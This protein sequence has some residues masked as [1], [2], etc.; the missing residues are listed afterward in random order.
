MRQFYRDIFG[1]ERISLN[2]QPE[3]QVASTNR[4]SCLPGDVLCT[5]DNT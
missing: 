1:Y 4:T 2:E 3:S 5:E